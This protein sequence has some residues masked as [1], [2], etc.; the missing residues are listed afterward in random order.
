MS[1]EGAG[2]RGRL[3]PTSAMWSAVLTS[4]L[5][6]K[7][8]KRTMGVVRG[9][10]EERQDRPNAETFHLKPVETLTTVLMIVWVLG[11]CSKKVLVLSLSLSVSQR[12]SMLCL[13]VRLRVTSYNPTP[14]LLEQQCFL[15]SLPDF[16]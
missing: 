3:W 11:A 16:C 15:L 9:Q 2:G 8:M 7:M 4:Q 12:I 5:M 13:A 6:M 1:P 14:W 10:W